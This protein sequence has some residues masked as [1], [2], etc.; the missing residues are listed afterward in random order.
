VRPDRLNETM[1]ALDFRLDDGDMRRI[2]N[3]RLAGRPVRSRARDALILAR[4]SEETS[5]AWRRSQL[6][7]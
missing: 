6:Q 7:A 1:G 4:F 5:R 2:K 3:A